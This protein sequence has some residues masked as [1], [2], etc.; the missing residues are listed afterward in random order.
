MYLFSMYIIPLS[1]QRED[2]DHIFGNKVGYN[3]GLVPDGLDL[4]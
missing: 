4:G 3:C 1:P 2:L